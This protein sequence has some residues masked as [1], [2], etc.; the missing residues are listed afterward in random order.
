MNMT[1]QKQ[2]PGST[3]VAAD[4]K[5]SRSRCVHFEMFLWRI[6]LLSDVCGST[7]AQGLQKGLVEV[8]MM[9]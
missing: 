1:L 8:E 2:K 5:A 4:L 3:A 6:K 7:Q 9:V